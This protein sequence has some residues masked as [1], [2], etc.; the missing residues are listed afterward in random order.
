MIKTKEEKDYKF[1]TMVLTTYA[2]IF[3]WF[4][5]QKTIK[6]MNEIVHALINNAKILI[7]EIWK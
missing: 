2:L 7:V 1:L 4:K 3:Y 6:N 5:Y